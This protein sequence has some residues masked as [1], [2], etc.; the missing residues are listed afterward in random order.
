MFHKT[1]TNIVPSIS[2]RVQ[3][4]ADND[5]TNLKKSIEDNLE[6]KTK[7]TF[8]WSHKVRKKRRKKNDIA[9]KSRKSPWGV[10]YSISEMRI[11]FLR[12]HYPFVLHFPVYKC[13]H[14]DLFC[15]RFDSSSFRQSVLSNN[16]KYSLSTANFPSA[17][18]STISLFVVFLMTLWNCRVHNLIRLMFLDYSVLFFTITTLKISCYYESCFNWYLLVLITLIKNLSSN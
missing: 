12:Y 13:L 5:E 11:I 7:E 10:L 6:D 2:P 1:I 15:L 3:P 14:T 8:K 9:D 16:W 4:A 17:F 18:Q